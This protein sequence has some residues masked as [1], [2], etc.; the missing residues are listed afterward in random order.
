M[1]PLTRTLRESL[2]IFIEN[3]TIRPDAFIEFIE[4]KPNSRP[5]LVSL[6]NHVRNTV[7]KESRHFELE[8]ALEDVLTKRHFVQVLPNRPVVLSKKCHLGRLTDDAL[9]HIASFFKFK[10]LRSF[11]ATCQRFRQIGLALFTRTPRNIQKLIQHELSRRIWVPLPFGADHYTVG[12]NLTLS[13]VLSVAALRQFPGVQQLKIL[14]AKITREHVAEI[15]QTTN[16]LRSFY[17]GNI[18]ELAEGGFAALSLPATL[19]SCTFMGSV[20][21]DCAVRALAK[22]CPLLQE[23]VLHDCTAVTRAAF[24]KENPLLKLKKLILCSAKYTDAG[25]S[26]V[27]S[28]CPSV[29]TLT[30]NRCTNFTG[31]SLFEF[32]GLEFL[33]ELNVE[34]THLTGEFF[35]SILDRAKNLVRLNVSFCDDI[36]SQAF[37]EV[38]YPPKLEHF[39]CN[40][41]EIDDD[42]LR[43]LLDS[44]NLKTLQLTSCSQLTS[45]LFNERPSLLKQEGFDFGFSSDVDAF[46]EDF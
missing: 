4:K 10:N 31:S 44:T 16:D 2:A 15:L 17:C 1:H 32:D 22:Q 39:S 23:L 20:A 41:T 19:E 42:G 35:K 11:T 28:C 21:T 13:K 9:L 8:S 36:A 26:H 6:F 12:Y 46:V 5:L 33:E 24:S 18:Q 25:L 40:W 29:H 30:I 27:L 38:V 37:V 7:D 45:Q 3:E 14:D 43:H 34:M